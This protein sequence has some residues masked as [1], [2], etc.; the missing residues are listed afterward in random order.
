MM[1][2]LIESFVR[3][4]IEIVQ[5][6]KRVFGASTD[7][8]RIRKENIVGETILDMNFRDKQ[9]MFMFDSQKEAL[10]YASCVVKNKT[11][12]NLNVT[13][14][15]CERTD[16]LNRCFEFHGVTAKGNPSRKFWNVDVDDNEYTASW[17]RIG[18]DGQSQ[19]EQFAS[20]YDARSKALKKIDEKL[21]E[22]YREVR[23]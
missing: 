19:T 10:R 11:R 13:K 8:D 7:G 9:T 5:D 16:D 23:C 22:G 2:Q 18:N 3:N 14:K 6:V 1:D 17:G 20:S 15:R 4:E 21:G 12:G